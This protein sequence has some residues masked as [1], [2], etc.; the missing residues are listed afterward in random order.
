[1]P[2]DLVVAGEG[3]ALDAGGVASHDAG[4]VLVEPDGH[5]VG[6]AQ[7]DVVAAA[8]PGD[9]D[10]AVVLAA[11]DGDDAAAIDVAVVLEGGAFD[12]AVG[13]GEQQEVLA[14]LEVADGHVLADAFA[15]AEFEHVDDGPTAAGARGLRD[16][17]DLHPED[18]AGVGK[19]QQVVVGGGDEDLL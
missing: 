2:D 9:A 12:Q 11:G 15:L 18:A 6:G 7:E 17:V 14:L 4:V 10:E 8:G 5:A 3:D 19:A 16:L 13:G 1:E